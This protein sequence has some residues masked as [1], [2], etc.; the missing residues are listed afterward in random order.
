MP[1]LGVVAGAAAVGV[2][3]RSDLL[4]GPSATAR[5]DRDL[6]VPSIVSSLV[7]TGLRLLSV[8]Y[9]RD[10]LLTVHTVWMVAAS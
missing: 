9:T 6:P 10:E 7:M 1:H 8:T 2:G 5:G 3:D 4:P